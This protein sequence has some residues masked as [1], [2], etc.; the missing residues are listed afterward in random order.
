L[1]SQA[2]SQAGTEILSILK[3]VRKQKTELSTIKLQ[4]EFPI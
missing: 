3:I 1:I 2:A 4:A